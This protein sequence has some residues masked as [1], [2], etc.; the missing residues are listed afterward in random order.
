[1]LN[2]NQVFHEFRFYVFLQIFHVITDVNVVKKYS[3][4]LFKK[5][6]FYYCKFVIG[7]NS[8]MFLGNYKNTTVLAVK[9]GVIISM[10]LRKYFQNIRNG[11]ILFI[12]ELFNVPRMKASCNGKNDFIRFFFVSASW[13]QIS[14]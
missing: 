11:C 4:I 13:N 7:D 6:D 10:Q 12:K 3:Q 8:F 5:H 1:M 2:L 9:Y 14:D